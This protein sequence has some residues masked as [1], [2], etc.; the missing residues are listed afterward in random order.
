[1][2]ASAKTAFVRD[3][4]AR[5]KSA[6]EAQFSQSEIEALLKLPQGAY[7]KYETH[8]LLPHHLILRFCL[9][10]GTDLYELFGAPVETTIRHMM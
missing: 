2:V 5:V 1:M 4:V 8:A 7:K 3:F 10:T 9:V 6:R